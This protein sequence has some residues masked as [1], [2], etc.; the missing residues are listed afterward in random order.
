MKVKLFD[1]S[2]TE[3]R[4]S[5]INGVSAKL[6]IT[7]DGQFVDFLDENGK[8]STSVQVVSPSSSQYDEFDAL[9]KKQMKANSKFFT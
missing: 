5:D 3:I 9:V 1:G 8:V 6:R 4:K 2:I 7:P